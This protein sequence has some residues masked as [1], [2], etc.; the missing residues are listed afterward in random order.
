MPDGFYL[1]EHPNPR[2]DHFYRSRRERVLAIVLHVTAGLEDLDG[3][4]DQSAEATAR[5]ASSTDREVSWHSGSDS[6]SALDLL[7][8]SFTAWAVVGF[9]SCTYSHE[10]S[11]S[12]PDWRDVPHT[13]IAAT[14]STAAAHLAPI[15]KALGVPLRKATRAELE[16]ARRT[17][18]A[19]VGFV[20]HSELDPARRRDPG[21]VSGVETFPWATFLDYTRELSEPTPAPPSAPTEGRETVDVSLPTLRPGSTETKHVAGLQGL[22]NAKAGQGLVVDG[23]FG[24]ATDRA[25][26]NWQAFFRLDVDGIAGPVTWKTLLEIP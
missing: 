2:G 7:P 18:G 16:H 4:E 5:Y 19:P 25:V 9:N 1:L 6:D 15:A 21:L 13:W 11:K 12:D 17:G 23:D 14:L 10:I 20:G 22:L 8:S 3:V 24:P 26:R